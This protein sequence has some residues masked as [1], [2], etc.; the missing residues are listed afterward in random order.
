[1]HVHGDVHPHIS[2]LS[3]YRQS[4][5]TGSS[6]SWEHSSPSEQNTD[7]SWLAHAILLCFVSPHLTPYKKKITEE[8]KILGASC[9]AHCFVAAH[10]CLCAVSSVPELCT[11]HDRPQSC[12]M[13]RS[14]QGCK[15]NSQAAEISDSQYIT[16][17]VEGEC[18]WMLYVKY[19]VLCF[20]F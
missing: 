9:S 2:Y 18:T 8:L 5:R 12:T 14:S 16:K 13:L 4:T 11:E 1:M 6:E 17:L 15:N 7:C 10:V 3:L 20:L 19:N